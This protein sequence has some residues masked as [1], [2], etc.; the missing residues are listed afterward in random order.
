MTDDDLRYDGQ[1]VNSLRRETVLDEL[2][3]KAFDA[4]AESEKVNT[5]E[6]MREIERMLMLNSVDSN[7][8]DHIDAMDDLRQSVSLQAYGQRDPVIEYKRE[9]GEIFDGMIDN[10]KE[11][12]AKKVMIV[13]LKS[14][15]QIRREQQARITDAS[16]AGAE[17]KKKP[18][19]TA[20]SQKVG[21]ND[22]CP[23][24]SGKK[25]KHCCGQ[26]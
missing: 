16:L 9:S 14:E 7:W 8:M 23:C 24:G 18:V 11:E 19:V 26:Q 21:R 25:Y 20:K 3:E 15:E 13:R 1:D 6:K 10:I 5:P 2:L 17:G 22:P 12:V 4:Y